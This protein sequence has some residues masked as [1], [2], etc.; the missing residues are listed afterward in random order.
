[1]SGGSVKCSRSIAFQECQRRSRVAD[2]L[3]SSSDDI[4]LQDLQT[5]DWHVPPTQPLCRGNGETGAGTTGSR[6]RHHVTSSGGVGEESSSSCGGTGRLERRLVRTMSRVCE[7]LERGERRLK[8]DDV[9]ASNRIAWQ[10]VSLVVDRLLLLV[11]TVGTVAITL[12]LNQS[13]LTSPV[14]A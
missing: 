1:M 4:T 10:Y 7:T 11:F 5:A 9:V 2:V 8:R 13:L 6:Y 14:L 12:V 3:T